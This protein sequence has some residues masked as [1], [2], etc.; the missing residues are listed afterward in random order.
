M[1][2]LD[3]VN[4]FICRDT[5]MTSLS[6]CFLWSFLGQFD[7]IQGYKVLFCFDIG[8]VRPTLPDTQGTPGKVH[9]DRLLTGIC[10]T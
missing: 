7:I 2:H 1:I 6:A 5:G 3:R 10:W 8:Q 9:G 4:N